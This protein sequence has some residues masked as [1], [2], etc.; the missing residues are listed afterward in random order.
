[1]AKT[2]EIDISPKYD[3]AAQINAAAGIKAGKDAPFLFP[4]DFGIKLVI[5]CD[6]NSDIAKKLK[7]DPVLLQLFFDA[8]NKHNGEVEKARKDL[9]RKFGDGLAACNDMVKKGNILEAQA[10]FAKYFTK[11]IFELN[12]TA[13]CAA[14]EK[15][16]SDE[17][18]ALK[19]A[20][21]DYRNYKLKV[22]AKF[23]V[24]TV[25]IGVNV[26]VNVAVIASSGFHFGA[27][28]FLSAAGLLRS[29]VALAKL[30]ADC[31]QGVDSAI[32]EAV[33]V[34]C[35]ITKKKARPAWV[36]NVE[37]LSET[38]VNEVVS[39]LV[40]AGE[41]FDTVKKCQHKVTL[42]RNKLNGT[43]VALHKLSE[44]VQKALDAQD[45]IKNKLAI[46]QS[47]G[48]LATIPAKYR[49]DPAKLAKS[50]KKLNKA[51]TKCADAAEAF[52]RRSDRLDM[53]EDLLKKLK[54]EPSEKV[55]E[56]LR[57][58]TAGA[59][60]ALIL[61]ATLATMDFSS[62]ADLASVSV[63]M[64][65]TAFDKASEIGLSM[66]EKADLDLVTSSPVFKA[67]AVAS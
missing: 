46:L 35:N 14:M 32:G 41:F 13:L 23:G 16:A 26:G 18:E 34:M 62:V 21:S 29:T 42:A 51:I 4:E 30:T 66:M 2:V 11:E 37:L 6:E 56:A 58:A 67:G 45:E 1:M 59:M 43:K 57:F 19:K 20:K 10:A 38:I 3:L 40:G 31:F 44:S 8:F 15:N 5:V 65:L 54:K 9:A 47:A 52:Q 22:A 28:I 53:V 61:A 36:S 64:G 49:F 50:E 7:K 63:D 33:D 12:S 60:K 17:W 25:G 48:A 39:E 24:I 55:T 27:G